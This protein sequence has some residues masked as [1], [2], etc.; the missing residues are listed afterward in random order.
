MEDSLREWWGGNKITMTNFIFQVELSGDE[1]KQKCRYCEKENIVDLTVKE[2][3]REETVL[4]FPET[5]ERYRGNS[6]SVEEAMTRYLLSSRHMSVRDRR[7]M[8]SYVSRV[9]RGI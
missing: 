2:Q 7:I 5:I 9:S 4:S 3:I 8:E 1:V 6:R